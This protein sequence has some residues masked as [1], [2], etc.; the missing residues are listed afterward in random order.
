M[1][2]FVLVLAALLAV[3]L[4]A[5]PGAVARPDGATADPGVTARSITIG[6]PPR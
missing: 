1:K 3:G 4:A 6:R 2:K 5:V